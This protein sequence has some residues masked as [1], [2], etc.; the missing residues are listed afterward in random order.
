MQYIS[1]DRHPIVLPKGFKKKPSKERIQFDRE[2]E[3]VKKCIIEENKG[4]TV[5]K[6]E[7]AE[8][9]YGG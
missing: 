8:K 3:E 5:Y 7:L 2:R 6:I 4:T 1:S 9:E